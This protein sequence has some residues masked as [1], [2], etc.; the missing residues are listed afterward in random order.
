MSIK[1]K[2]KAVKGFARSEAINGFK[3]PRGDFR[4][5]MVKETIEAGFKKPCGDFIGFTNKATLT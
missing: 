5:F 1:T 4:G 3:R 2:T